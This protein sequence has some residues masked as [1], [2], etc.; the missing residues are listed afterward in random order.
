MLMFHGYR[1]IRCSSRSIRAAMAAQAAP[2]WRD[3][4]PKRHH[5]ATEGLPQIQINPAEL[6]ESPNVA[7]KDRVRRA[8]A[9]PTRNVAGSEF[10]G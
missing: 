9:L 2:G 4:R 8:A 5:K 7:S 6:S 1:W 10:G 3:A